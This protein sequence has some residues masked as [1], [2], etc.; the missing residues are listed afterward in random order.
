M[1]PLS[2]DERKASAEY[3]QLIAGDP[4]VYCGGVSGTVDHVTPVRR[5]GTD[6]ADNLAPACQSC[7][8]VKGTRS[9]LAALLYMQNK[10]GGVNLTPPLAR[11]SEAPHASAGSA[12]SAA[13]AGH[14]AR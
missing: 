7:N 11:R 12:R 3:R 13:R 5:G 8:S 2:S 10:P 14:D 4:C 9:L 6:R 1:A